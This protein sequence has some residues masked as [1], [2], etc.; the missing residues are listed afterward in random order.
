MTKREQ[1]IKDLVNDVDVETLLDIV[2]DINSWD[3]SL[4][5]YRLYD[6]DE[7]NDLHCDVDPFDIALRV[8]NSD[9]FDGNDMYFRY[10][11]YDNLVSVYEQ[12]AFA[13]VEDNAE[14]II[15]RFVELCE[16]GTGGYMEVD[17]Y[18]PGELGERILEIC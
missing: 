6:M 2:R 9:Y 13:E 11:V 7:F 10:D 17:T 14:E 1:L 15:E 12:D 4:D 3:G 5:D 16:L 8:A 18:F